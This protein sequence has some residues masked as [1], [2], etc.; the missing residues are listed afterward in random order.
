AYA[1]AGDDDVDVLLPDA[2]GVPLRLRVPD[3]EHAPGHSV[4]DDDHPVAIFSGHRA[5]D[6]SQRRG[7]ARALAAIRGARRVGHDRDGARGAAIREARLVPTE[8]G[9]N[10]RVHVGTSGYNYPEWKGTFYPDT[11]KA[12]A[13][14]D[15]YA[16]R[17]H[18]VEINYTFRRMPTLPLMTKW[19]D[20]A[21]A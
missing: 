21:P 7:T 5:W 12:S 13:M 14:F 9:G 6:L 17:F 10:M 11:I 4:G 8:A 20:Q 1:A 19:R 2:D 15:Y 3:R 16:E 18:T